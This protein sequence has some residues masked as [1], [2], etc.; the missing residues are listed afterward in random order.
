MSQTIVIDI[1]SVVP[2]LHK[3]GSKLQGTPVPGLVDWVKKAQ[4]KGNAV[5]FCSGNA[6]DAFVRQLIE[7]YLEQIGLRSVFV[8]HGIP[9][10]FD[11]FIARNAFPFDGTFPQVG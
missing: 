5:F 4:D 3:V 9:D 6:Y 1:Y 8:T 11:L 7:R 10:G 2:D